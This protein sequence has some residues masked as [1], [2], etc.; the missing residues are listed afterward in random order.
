MLSIKSLSAKDSAAFSLYLEG[1]SQKITKGDSYYAG[2]N[3]EPPGKWIGTYSDKMGIGASRVERGELAAAF[4]GVHPRTGEI[5]ANN[6][7]EKHKPG[8]D[9][10]FAAPKSVS[11]AFATANDKDRAIISAAQQKAVERAIKHAELT[12]AFRQ[13]EGKG[14]EIKISQGELAVATFEHCNNRNN[15][16]HL[17]THTV[18]MNLAE[19]GKTVD[20]DASRT[21]EIDGIYKATL[22]EALKEAGYHV[23]RDGVA[24][25]LHEVSKRFEKDESSRH[26]EI[27]EDMAVTGHGSEKAAEAAQKKTRKA[28]VEVNRSTFFADKQESAKKYAMDERGECLK[29]QWNDKRLLSRFNQHST[30][31]ETQMKAALFEEAQG[32]C[33]V[34]EALERMGAMVERG[35]LLQMTDTRTGARRWTTRENWMIEK[36]LSDWAK[37]EASTVRQQDKGVSQNALKNAEGSRTMSA[38]QRLAFLDVTGSGRLKVVQGAAGT[39]KSYMLGAAGDAWKRDGFAVIGCAPS[40]KAAAGLQE[41]SGI[42]STTVHKLL[43]DLKKG[44]EKLTEKSVVVMDEAGMVGSKLMLRLKRE[45]EKAGA[46][47]VLVGDTRQLQPIDA[48]GAMRAIKAHTGESVLDDIRRQKSVEDISLVHKLKSGGK[49]DEAVADMKSRGMLK[50]SETREESRRKIAEL[51]VGDMKGGHSVLGLA[52]RRVDTK[53][54]NEIARQLARDSGLIGQADFDYKSN[55]GGVN[56]FAVGDSV[57]ATKNDSKIGIK[58]GMVGKV[59]SA[60]KGK[61]TVEMTS[62]ERFTLD[63]KT[64]QD[65]DRGYCVTIHKSQG[66]TVDRAHI[67]HDQRM[68]SMNMAY[69]GLSR[70]R[71]AATYH[72]SVDD[73]D[74]DLQSGQNTIEEEEKLIGQKIGRPDEKLS[75][76][77][78]EFSLTGNEPSFERVS[79]G[80]MTFER[81]VMPDERGETLIMLDDEGHSSVTVMRDEVEVQHADGDEIENE[82]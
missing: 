3:G 50:R 33:G 57:L 43:I 25:R 59:V 58:N 6:A 41:G 17:H 54:I 9:L 72:Y 49:G 76:S 18:V 78:P 28:K 60:S 82:M 5:I 65:L 81:E 27:I 31:T 10:T 69:V 70:H 37:L 24:F 48:G 80:E 63:D 4:R 75:S 56:S 16:S 71:H 79:L 32:V 47:L 40:G 66:E 45:V 26:D 29:P 55:S 53:H 61:L 15:D 36:E 39:G 64:Y 73:L 68:T 74:L 21:K 8:Y 1:S 77:E 13:R 67:M 12:G 14:G 52:S 34:D 42:E 7:G 51:I 19:N 35:D 30:I 2:E 23:E 11:I 62:G 22:A 44:D 20:F 38:E 46:K